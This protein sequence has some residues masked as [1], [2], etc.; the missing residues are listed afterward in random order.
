[1]EKS[2]KEEMIACKLVLP[3]VGGGEDPNRSSEDAEDC[4]EGW[5]DTQMLRLGRYKSW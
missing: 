5:E 3:W 1:M 4:E 2:L